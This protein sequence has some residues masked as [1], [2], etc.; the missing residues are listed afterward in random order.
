[1]AGHVYILASR[2]HGTLYIGCTSDLARRLF[3]HRE[4][5]APGFTRRHSVKRLVWFEAHDDIE[6]AILRERRLKEW[7]RAWKIQLIEQDN[8]AW[9][10]LA[11]SMLGFEPLQSDLPTRHP[12]ESR[13][14]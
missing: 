8:P 3:E 10:D 5:L 4:G 11:V 13:G 2:R 12:G 7:K 14:P 6:S 9:D 1:L